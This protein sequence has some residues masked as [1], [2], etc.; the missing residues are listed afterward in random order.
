MC[1]CLSLS[2]SVCVCVSVVCLFPVC[3][4]AVSCERQMEKVR[5]GC[6]I[7]GRVCEFRQSYQ[8]SG[9]HGAVNQE[10]C[11]QDDLAG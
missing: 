9:M 3:F 7:P 8:K 4:N 1:V 10:A 2:L 6:V 5:R 11:I